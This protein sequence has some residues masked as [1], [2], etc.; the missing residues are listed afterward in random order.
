M[1]VEPVLVVPK[2]ILYRLLEDNE[3]DG[4]EFD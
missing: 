4:K 2:K 3:R 1:T